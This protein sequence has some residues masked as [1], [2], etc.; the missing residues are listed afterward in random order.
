MNS[1]IFSGQ[2]SHS[3][4]TPLEHSFRYGVYMIYLD[5]GELDQVFA[6]RWFWSCKRWALA[7]F[8][9]E[10]HFGDPQKSLDE[11]V[12]DLVESRT[13]CRP[14]GPIRLLT[15][16]AYFG[17]CFNPISVYYCF[18]REDKR[19]VTI[20]AEVS[21]TPWGETH[22]YVLSDKMNL[23]DEETRRFATG[24]ELHVSPFMDMDVGY[25]WLLTEPGDDL[26][27]RISNFVEKKRIF[28]ATLNLQREE[29]SGKSL[30]KVLTHYPLM[31]MK[32]T[33]AIYWQALKLWIKGCPLYTHPGKT[34]T[35]Q[36]NS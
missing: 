30:A 22:C 14:E 29:I 34:K 19:V 15:N 17:Y 10:Q 26:V 1:S 16:L 2:V 27:V 4:K 5:L 36:A 24:K 3:R 21:N 35:I 32:I 8:R 18:D 7:R 31:T 9:R 11:T 33:L 12:R 20:V 13:E 25:D 28:S 6:G 23:G